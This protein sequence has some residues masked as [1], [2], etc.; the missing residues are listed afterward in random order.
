M[1]TQIP[2]ELQGRVFSARDTPQYMSIPIGYFLGGALADQVFEPLMFSDSKLAG[3]L[4]YFVGRGPGSGMAVI[5]VLLGIIGFIGCL[6]F[7]R[8]KD[9]RSLNESSDF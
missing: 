8:S 7:R 6:L 3:Y 9:I 1:R 4:S 5:L 2:M